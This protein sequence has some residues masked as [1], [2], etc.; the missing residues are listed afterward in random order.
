MAEA[1]NS[2]KKNFEEVFDAKLF[3]TANTNAVL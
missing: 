3:L 2:I 1:E